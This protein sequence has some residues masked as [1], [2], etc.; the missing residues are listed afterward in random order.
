[1]PNALRPLR[2][3]PSCAIACFIL[4]PGGGIGRH[5][6]LKIP[7]SKGCAGSSPALGTSE[8]IE[9]KRLSRVDAK[10]AFW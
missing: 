1:M 2:N 8:I 4:C 6:G 3:C 7:R 9:E 5:K 10:G